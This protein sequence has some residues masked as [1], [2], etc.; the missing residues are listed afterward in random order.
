MTGS[1]QI[2]QVVEFTTTPTLSEVIRVDAV[3]PGGVVNITLPFAT[4]VSG[5]SPNRVSLIVTKRSDA[6]PD[7]LTQELFSASSADDVSA[8]IVA[9]WR[10]DDFMARF[11]GQ[12]FVI[13]GGGQTQGIENKNLPPG[14]FYTFVRLHFRNA[15]NN[16]KHSSTR[17]SK[18]IHVVAKAG[19]LISSTTEL[20]TII[21]AAMT[22]AFV[23]ISAIVIFVVRR[24]MS[25]DKP[26][27]SGIKRSDEY[28]ASEHV[29]PVKAP[30]NHSLSKQ[31][32]ELSSKLDALKANGGLKLHDE[33]HLIQAAEDMPAHAQQKA[34]EKCRYGNSNCPDHSRVQL[35]SG[36]FI[37]ANWIEI[38]TN[39]KAI[40]TQGPLENTIADFWQMTWENNVSCIVMLCELEERGRSKCVQYWPQKDMGD[41][42]YGSLTISLTEESHLAF[43]SISRFNLANG[44]Q[45]REVYQIRFHGWPDCGVPE[46]P[47]QFLALLERIPKSE[48]R[49]GPIIAHCSAGLGRTGCLL[50][51]LAMLQRANKSMSMEPVE[52]LKNMRVARPGLVQSEEQYAFVV[53]SV[54]E[55]LSACNFEF[56][57][58]IQA[59]E[60][61][62]TIERLSNV[63]PA[64]GSTGFE[65]EF[66]RLQLMPKGRVHAQ[67]ASLACNKKKNRLVNV[68]PYDSSRVYLRPIRG[69]EGSDYINASF[70]DGYK[71]KGAY[72]ATQAPMANTTDEFWRMI[73]ENNVTMIV[74]LT[75]LNE[76]GREKCTKYWPEGKKARY[77]YYIVESTTEFCCEGFV[78]R[79][80]LMTD[81]RDGT[82]RTVRQFHFVSWPEG[83]EVPSHADNFI[84]LIGQVHKTREQF[85]VVGP[86]CVHCSAGV[87][88]TG[89]FIGLT[90]ILERLRCEGEVDVFQTVKLMRCRRPGMIQTAEQYQFIYRASLEYL[91]NF[92]L[93]GN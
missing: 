17:L 5:V 31:A 18:P 87:G 64:S 50:L 16:W 1:D 53:E 7:E 11:A 46:F 32:T 65:D 43:W 23:F 58:Q 29:S 19:S 44:S 70:I 81:A 69:I 13:G 21:I 60:I 88:R 91:Q 33:W 41:A 6:R 22:L 38:E 27:L 10:Y 82:S 59:R 89:V 48:E 84:D 4:F 55:A 67:A 83:A 79:E 24:R 78:M 28:R 52:L 86:I 76:L 42:H 8:W 35:R 51:A 15:V 61:P 62:K 93:G 80:F 3:N 92:Y 49:K 30:S 57:T 14:V 26:Y 56:G 37:H 71:E 20:G 36:D 40:A 75:Q 73:W 66:K 63:D 25:G 68:L 90:V 2:S 85:G 54:V 39:E 12:S 74:M 72:I 9:Q 45:T 47:A 34:L 77:T